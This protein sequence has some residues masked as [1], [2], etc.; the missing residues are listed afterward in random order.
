MVE[1][2][3]YVSAL[4]AGASGFHKQV[5]E[6]PPA[7]SVRTLALMPDPSVN[8]R[9]VT[10]AR[11]PTDKAPSA[12]RVGTIKVPR[13]LPYNSFN[14][15]GYNVATGDTS[16]PGSLGSF[17]DKR[18]TVRSVLATPV[19]L[20]A[21]SK[22]VVE[23]NLLPPFMAFSVLPSVDFCAPSDD[24]ADLFDISSDAKQ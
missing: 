16:D 12:I 24:S 20:G 14:I 22:A 9:F 13:G 6:T 7:T 21:G 1:L 19:S 11:T 4:V 3:Q 15:L 2:C 10:A 8:G 18:K 17:S 23:P 5:K